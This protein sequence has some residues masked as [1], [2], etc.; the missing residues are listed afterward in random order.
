MLDIIQF[1]DPVLQQ[2]SE[3]LTFPL[4]PEDKKLAAGMLEI[5][6]SDPD[7]YAGLS[8]VQVGILKRI[9]ICQRY[10]KR[11][12]DVDPEW[13]TMINAEIVSESAK[14][15]ERWDGCLSVKNGQLFAKTL[16]ADRVTVEY[17]DL[18]GEK[19]RMKAKGFFSHVVQHEVDHLHGILFIKYVDDPSDFYTA[20]QLDEMMAS[21]TSEK[22]GTEKSKQSEAGKVA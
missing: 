13:V 17:F 3:K 1:P 19:Q 8:A 12:E 9:C 22:N 21:E 7:H 20:E 16:R 18:N 15:V 6:Q 11:S 14:Q 2:V 10:D 5:L 4:A